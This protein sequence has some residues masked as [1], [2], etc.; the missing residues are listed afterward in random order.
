MRPPNIRVAS[1]TGISV[2]ISLLSFNRFFGKL[3][4]ALGAGDS[5]YDA[6]EQQVSGYGEPFGTHELGVESDARIDH[7]DSLRKDV[8]HED[9]AQHTEQIGAAVDMEIGSGLAVGGG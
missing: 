8:S 1:S 2:V 4:Y 3:G 6:E 9:V 7:E 5:K